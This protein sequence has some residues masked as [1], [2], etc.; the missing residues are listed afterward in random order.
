MVLSC[1]SSNLAALTLMLLFVIKFAE[2][3]P[4][5]FENGAHNSQETLD[6]RDND[7]AEFV[8]EELNGLD[9][10][11]DER[12]PT[13]NEKDDELLLPRTRRDDRGIADITIHRRR[14]HHRNKH[15]RQWYLARLL[16]DVTGRHG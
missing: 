10:F 4:V 1:V 3:L 6:S 11:F 5:N 16:R 7:E 9:T 15:S 12:V 8:S 14:V 13:Q 2:P